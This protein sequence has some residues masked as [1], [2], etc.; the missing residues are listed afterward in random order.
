MH[1]SVRIAGYLVLSATPAALLARALFA[2]DVSAV[3]AGLEGSLVLVGAVT[4]VRER[5]RIFAEPNVT[6]FERGDAIEVLAVA[7]AAAL[8]YLLSVRAGFGPVV[9]SALVGLAAG[10]FAHKIAV[11]AYCGSFVGMAS[12][13]VFPSIEYLA[14][15]GLCSGLAFVAAKHAFAGFGGKLGTLA[16]FGCATTVALTGADYAAGSALPWTTAALVVPVAA[17][18]AVAAAVLNLRLELG[19]VA[20]SALVGLGAGLGFPP[21]LAGVG[22]TLAAA[23][24]CAS[25]VGMSSTER[26]ADEWRVALAGVVSGLVFVAVAAALSGAGGKL[27]TVAF[28]SCVTVSGA[29]RLA[30]RTP[31][32]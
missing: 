3:V 21:L 1:L 20:G 16:L 28:V 9:A 7:V 32:A 23:A 18:G 6:G 26:L 19:A 31:P 17:V 13:E 27:G 29:E 8:T 10:V 30:A 24:F 5:E 25:F 12:P 15:A 4:V 14:V 11:P 22:E 2:D